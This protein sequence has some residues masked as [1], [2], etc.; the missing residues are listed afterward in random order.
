MP[1]SS[2]LLSAAMSGRTNE[3]TWVRELAVKLRQPALDL[4]DK[5]M[6]LADGLETG[7]RRQG[8]DAARTEYSG[9]VVQVFNQQIS[10]S[11]PPIIRGVMQGNAGSADHS[12]S[13]GTPWRAAWLSL[14]IPVP[15][16]FGLRASA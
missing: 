8:I 10:R 6:L 11:M 14:L 13:T 5:L 16:I 12:L 1:F 3:Q 15:D 9:S 4:L 7:V 2:T